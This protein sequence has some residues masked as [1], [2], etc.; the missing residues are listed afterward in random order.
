MLLSDVDQCDHA[1]SD[2]PVGSAADALKKHELMLVCAAAG[3]RV[4]AISQLFGTAMAC[5]KRGTCTWELKKCVCTAWCYSDTYAAHVHHVKYVSH[6]HSLIVT[7]PS[8]CWWCQ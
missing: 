1:A 6:C 8:C 3:F 7:Y 5:Q 2:C 4:H